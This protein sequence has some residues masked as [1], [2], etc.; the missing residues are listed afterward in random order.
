MDRQRQGLDEFYRELADR[1]L[2]LR[3][4]GLALSAL[5]D[6]RVQSWWEEGVPIEL[7]LQEVEDE[8]RR[9]RDRKNKRLNLATVNKRLGKRRPA[10]GWAR[11]RLGMGL[12]AS[13][14][15]GAGVA[16]PDGAALVDPVL[17]RA[18]GLPALVPALEAL[19]I[20]AQSL[21]PVRVR[22]RLAALARVHRDAL[23][24]AL[25]DTERQDWVEEIQPELGVRLR[26]MS[27]QARAETVA[28]HL[29]RRVAK[30]DRVLQD[31]EP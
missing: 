9:A 3:A 17:E 11:A 7:A 13:I 28:E 29:R 15:E 25:S 4:S 2:D 23:V 20:E 18:R 16:V 19:R 30:C 21:A 24:D 1:I 31:S 12:G 10:E 14:D 8:A 5:E 22:A 26:R 6:D 27:A